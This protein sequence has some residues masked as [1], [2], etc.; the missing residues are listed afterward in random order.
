MAPHSFKI[1]MFHS[2]SDVSFPFIDQ[3]DGGSNSMHVLGHI[4]VPFNM[5]DMTTFPVSS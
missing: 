2:N 5:Q 3:T 4:G 1:Y